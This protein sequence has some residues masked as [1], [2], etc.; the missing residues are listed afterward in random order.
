M[1]RM[2]KVIVK[3]ILAYELDSQN[4]DCIGIYLAQ[5]YAQPYHW[6]KRITI[7][8][9]FLYHFLSFF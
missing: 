6:P 7:S 8:Q 9:F 2:K 1:G 4:P 5:T 3:N